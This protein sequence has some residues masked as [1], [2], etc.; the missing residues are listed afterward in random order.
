MLDPTQI[1]RWALASN[2]DAGDCALPCFACGRNMP[3]GHGRFCSDRCREFYDAG[4][5]LTPDRDC[6]DIPPDGWLVVA[7]P[8]GTEIGSRYY[9]DVL[10]PAP[11]AMARWGAG[12]LIACAHCRQE[13]E[14]KGLRCCS[15]NCE[16]AYS[17]RQDNL[18]VLA[19]AGIEVA[20]KRQCEHCGAP[21]P[22]WRNGRR[23]SRKVKFCSRKCQQQAFRD[24]KSG[25][26][27]TPSR[28][29]V[30]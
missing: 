8:P 30:L 26:S 11:A 28:G 4:G 7:G 17:E 20:T 21:I 19:A 13:F 16:C 1:G 9:A 3:I 27:H 22:P 25:G 18:K 14:S 29:P 2:S 24:D 15:S 10:G 5:D 6:L 23:V 12:F